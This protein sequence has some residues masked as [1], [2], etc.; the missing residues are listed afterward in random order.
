MATVIGTVIAGP[1]VRALGYPV[2]LYAGLLGVVVA[3]A[4]ARGGLP[5]RDPAAPTPEMRDTR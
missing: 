2:A 3:A 5:P 1:A 4:I